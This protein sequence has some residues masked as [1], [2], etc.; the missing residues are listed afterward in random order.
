MGNMRAC[1]LFLLLSLVLG[2]LYPLFITMI[3]KICLPHQSQ[4]S[5]LVVQGRIVGSKLIGQTFSSEKYFWSRPSATTYHTL[6]SFGS[7]LGPTSH[8]LQEQVQQRRQRFAKQEVPSD[9]L[10]SSASGLD[11]H[12]TVD[13]AFFQAPRVA[14]ARGLSL[15]D[16]EKII[17][18]EIKK[19]FLG[20][21]YVNVLILNLALDRL[22]DSKQQSP[23]IG[24]S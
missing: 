23:L 1:K 8:L 20:P 3:G 10:F 6:P 16:I 24:K 13:A 12:I 14:Q 15:Q 9:L 22:Q 21:S 2:I 5:L 17:Q 4:G 18:E 19:P 11:P 7:N